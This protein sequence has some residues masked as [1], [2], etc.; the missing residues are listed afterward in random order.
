M[1]T[2]HDELCNAHFTHK[3]KTSW[4]DCD[5]CQFIDT[6]RSDESGKYYQDILDIFDTGYDMGRSDA[7]KAIEDGDFVSHPLDH[8]FIFISH[9]IKAARGYIDI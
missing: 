4:D 8:D 7:A 9:A 1:E 6:I 2:Q 3:A 5:V